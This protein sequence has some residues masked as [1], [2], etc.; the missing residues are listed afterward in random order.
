MR[1]IFPEYFRNWCMESLTLDELKNQSIPKNPIFH[2]REGINQST[3]M[4]NGQTYI[5]T[6]KNVYML[7]PP[8][9]MFLTAAFIA[10]WYECSRDWLSQSVYSVSKRPKHAVTL[11]LISRSKVYLSVLLV[12]MKNQCT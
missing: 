4:T 6:L 2:R 8:D 7:T 12:Y 11:L 10:E 1:F 3:M 9:T 5:S